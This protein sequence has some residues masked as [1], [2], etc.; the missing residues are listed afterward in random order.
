MDPVSQTIQA[1]LFALFSFI[2][3][4]L[5]AVLG[6]TYDH[7]FV[8][9]MG[10]AA[11]YPPLGPGATGAGGFLSEAA[12]FSQY[13]VLNLVDPA[14]VLVVV[15]VGI[16]YLLK[17]TF[18]ALEPKLRD[19]FPR[20]VAAALLAN[21]T[22]PISGALLGVA[23]ATYSVISSFDGGAWSSWSNLG[24]FGL[25][26]FSWD[27]GVLAFVVAFVLLSLVLLLAGAVAVRDA[28]LGVLLVLLPV[29]TLLWPIPT[30]APLARRGWLWFGELAFLPSIMVIPLELAV[31]SSSVLLLMGYLVICLGSPALVSLARQSLTGVGFPSAGGALSGGVQR[32]LTAA[33]VAL[34][35]LSGSLGP[36]SRGSGSG[37]AVAGMIRAGG[38][39]PLPLA[40]PVMGAHA[41]G[42]GAERLIRH[43]LASGRGP[44]SGS[45]AI[46]PVRSTRSEGMGGL[47]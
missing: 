27:N 3:A 21:F 47:R 37:G 9:E 44:G 26:Q 34:E 15:A 19:L 46:P 31:G 16:L 20:L 30:L 40:L 36:G 13:L 1:L 33:S 23:G 4:L 42:A 39:A 25:F 11:L 41:I 35:P 17:A 43:V 29:F 45:P 28:L 5:A 2:T 8:P 32:G 14:L 18:P 38:R 10:A 12:S 24:G 6:P 22:L 7:L